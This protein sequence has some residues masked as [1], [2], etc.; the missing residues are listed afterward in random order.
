MKTYKIKFNHVTPLLMKSTRGVNPLDP[1]V[2]EQKSLTSLR[3]KTDDD[4]MRLMEIDY[5]LGAYY[6]DE[7]GFYIPAE[8]IEACIREGAK[9]NR[10]G[11]KAK[12]A[13]FVNQEKIK[14]IHNGPTELMEAYETVDYKD[15]RIVTVN[16]AKITR[17]RPRFNRWALEFT[18]DLDTDIMNEDE[19]LTALD[20]AGRQKG[21]GD[22][23]PRY[24]R[25]AVKVEQVA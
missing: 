21:L 16:R 4:I 18:V 11:E 17:C 24:G 22:Y 2:K 3:K 1:L 12:I 19:F 6:D 7:V 23:R 13:I 25:F 20:I 10:L 9:A 14:L 5:E 15:I 8:M